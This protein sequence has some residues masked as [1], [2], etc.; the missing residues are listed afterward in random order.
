[1]RLFQSKLAAFSLLLILIFVITGCKSENSLDYPTPDLTHLQL[2]TLDM[3]QQ[4]IEENYIYPNEIPDSWHSLDTNLRPSIEAGELSYSEFLDAVS[5]ILGEF[6][7]DTV[8]MITRDQTVQALMGRPPYYGGVGAYTSF[9]IEPEN[10][11]VLLMVQPNSPADIAG[12]QPHDRILSIDGI[13]VTSENRIL[14][15]GEEATEVVL[16]VI[17]P[18]EELRTITVER[19]IIEN[20]TTLNRIK[21]EDVGNGIVHVQFPPAN[22]QG[23]LQDFSIALMDVQSASSI[24]GLVLDLRLVV[25]GERWT[26][27]LVEAILELLTEDNIGAFYALDEVDPLSIRVSETRW[28]DIPITII[29]GPDTRGGAEILAASLQA[30]GRA[31]V[32]GL[33]TEGATELRESFDLP[34]GSQFLVAT[35]SY[36]PANDREV[37]LLGVEPNVIVEGD[38]HEITDDHDPVLNEALDYLN[39]LL[40]N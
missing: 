24:Q 25:S 34:D 4:T 32:Y 19:A 20:I 35:S 33:P 1:M 9:R 16:E 2:E 13:G 36:R 7:T 5:A 18:G 37:G 23:L 31:V 11:V 14:L 40:G 3:L 30:T 17:S 38:W 28:H 22:Y 21:Y 26:I 10:A 29:V 6:P 39:R 12:L 8:Q 15:R 27:E